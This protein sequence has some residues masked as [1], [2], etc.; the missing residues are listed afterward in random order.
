MHFGRSIQ[1][2]AHTYSTIHA[3]YID[4]LDVCLLA[5][6]PLLFFYFDSAEEEKRRINPRNLGKYLFFWNI[7]NKLLVVI[8]VD[9]EVREMSGEAFVSSFEKILLQTFYFSFRFYD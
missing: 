4:E 7:N 6:I 8:N 9:Y 3:S 1:F 2:V 5:A